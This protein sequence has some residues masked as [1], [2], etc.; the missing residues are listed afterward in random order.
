MPHPYPAYIHIK[1]LLAGGD[2][3]KVFDAVEQALHMW[4]ERASIFVSLGW[5]AC[6]ALQDKSR[7]EQYQSRFFDL[8]LNPGDTVLDMGSGHFPLPYATTLADISLTDG[9][10]GRAGNE[11][12]LVAGK[13]VVE[14]TVEETPFADKEFDFVYCSHVLEH[15]TDPEKACAELMRIGK[16]GYIETPKPGKD[17][18]FNTAAVSNHKWAVEFIH[19]VLTF[20]EYEEADLIRQYNIAMEMAACPQSFKEQYFS[21]LQ[22]FRAPSFNTMFMWEDCFDVEVRRKKSI[23]ANITLPSLSRPDVPFENAEAG[24]TNEAALTAL[25]NTLL[26]KSVYKQSEGYGTRWLL[27]FLPLLLQRRF[28]ARRAFSPEK[29]PASFTR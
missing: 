15:V 8:K 1:N 14:C 13:R 3:Q 23:P 25:E 10:I 21:L 16:R 26:A 5:E 17:V 28:T 6:A 2:H 20:R 18:L 24:G 22:I 4:P 27:R 29:Q 11:F 12:K 9:S 7:Y 19:G